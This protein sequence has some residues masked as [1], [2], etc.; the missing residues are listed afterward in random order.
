[1]SANLD[2]PRTRKGAGTYSNDLPVPVEEG[3]F[4][5]D[6]ALQAQAPS[7]VDL[8][9]LDSRHGA[10]RRHKGDDVLD[11]DGSVITAVHHEGAWEMT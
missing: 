4:N 6:S 10:I 3:E 11:V 9:S 5:K 7:K 2:I 8:K 1:M